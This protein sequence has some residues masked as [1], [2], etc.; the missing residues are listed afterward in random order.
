MNYYMLNQ[1]LAAG[2]YMTTIVVLRLGLISLVIYENSDFT[3]YVAD[4]SVANLNL[5]FNSELHPYFTDKDQKYSV[6]LQGKIRASYN[7][8]YNYT[9]SSNKDV[10]IYVDGELA[11]DK[12]GDFKNQKSFQREMY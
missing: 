3:G 4:M 12:S 5:T 1:M 7:D 8:W 6:T 2:Q 9:V 11:M 10:K